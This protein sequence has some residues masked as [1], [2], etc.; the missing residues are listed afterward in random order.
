MDGRPNEKQN[1]NLR[2]ETKTDRRRQ[3]LKLIL[4]KLLMVSLS[5]DI[6]CSLLPVHPSLPHMPVSLSLHF[7][8]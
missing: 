8:P 6:C 2:F 7:S 1:F 4:N 3:G 5:P